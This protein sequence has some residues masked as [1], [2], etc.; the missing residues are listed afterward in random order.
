MPAPIQPTFVNY[1]SAALGT[2][3]TE[4]EVAVPAG[5]VRVYLRIENNHA[6]QTVEVNLGAAAAEKPI[7]LLAAGE[8]LEM[9]A[10]KYINRV[11]QERI[12]LK[13][14]AAAT[15]YGARTGI[16]SKSSLNNKV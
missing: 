11:P 15:V 7:A 8:V 10:D 12:S 14:S 16:V 2:A 13:G 3:L 1:N 6:T 5:K 4:L 9:I